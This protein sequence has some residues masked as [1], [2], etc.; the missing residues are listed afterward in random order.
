[1]LRE[2]QTRFFVYAYS[3]TFLSSSVL[4][5]VCGSGGGGEGGGVTLVVEGGGGG[6]G[7][8]C[9]KVSVLFR[10]VC[11]VISRLQGQTTQAAK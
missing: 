7:V 6:G 8:A 1:M 10:A 9:F 4:P 11:N 3:A 5:S 2:T